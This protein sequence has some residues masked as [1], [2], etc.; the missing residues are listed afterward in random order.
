LIRIAK[1]LRSQGRDG[2]LKLK[3]HLEGSRDLFFFA[4]IR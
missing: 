1:I 4:D 2:E 3:L